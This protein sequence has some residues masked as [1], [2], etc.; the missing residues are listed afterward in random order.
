MV[1]FQHIDK[2][3][4]AECLFRLVDS[5]I[6]NVTTTTTTKVPKHLHIH[7]LNITWPYNYNSL[8]DK[9]VLFSMSSR[10][11]ANILAISKLRE[12]M[13]WTLLKHYYAYY[14][15]TNASHGISFSSKQNKQTHST[16]HS[17]PVSLPFSR[18][19]VVSRYQNFI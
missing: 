12:N 2:Q 7:R 11:N 14:C 9:S 18:D 10:N 8:S 19:Q 17:F 5:V 16:S 1:H 13:I 15:T 3:E 6:S 4:S